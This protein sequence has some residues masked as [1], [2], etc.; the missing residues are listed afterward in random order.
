MY[1]VCLQTGDSGRDATA[2]YRNPDLL[3]HVYAGPYIV[4]EPELAFVVADEHGVAGYVLAAEDTRAFEAWA[5]SNWWPN[6]REQYPL[7]DGDSPDTA[8]I[9]L[10]HDPPLAAADIL[11]DHPAHLHIDLLPRLQGSGYGRRLIELILAKLRERGVGGVHLGVAAKN[12]RAIAFYR[13]LGFRML[14]ADAE[15]E[16]MGMRLD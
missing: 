14:S 7:A 15:G 13:H 12:P 1:R 6:L 9:R 2:L 3:G 10:I 11:A 5:E 8:L 4:G 16:V